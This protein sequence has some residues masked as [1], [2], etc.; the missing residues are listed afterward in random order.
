MVNFTPLERNFYILGM[1]F[2]INLSWLNIAYKQVN[3]H[4]LMYIIF[5]F[6]DN[7]LKFKFVDY[8]CR[9]SNAMCLFQSLG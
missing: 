4:H 3:D 7:A 2:K 1:L 5:V 6:T 9:F 8:S